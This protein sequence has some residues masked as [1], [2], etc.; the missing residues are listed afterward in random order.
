MKTYLAAIPVWA[1]DT[2]INWD[3]GKGRYPHLTREQSHVLNEWLERIDA[4]EGFICHEPN[5]YDQPD[6]PM[7]PAF[8]DVCETAVCYFSIMND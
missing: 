4:C 6:T 8:G 3:Y 5:E 1:L 7:L 2:L